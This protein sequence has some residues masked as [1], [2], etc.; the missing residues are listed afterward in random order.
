MGIRVDKLGDVTAARCTSCMECVAACPPKIGSMS[1]GP[2]KWLGWAWPTRSGGLAMGAVVVLVL[3]CLGGAVGATYMAPLPSFVHAEGTPPAETASVIL[4][5][6]GVKCRHGTELFFEQ[7]RRK[8]ELGVRG[9]L[10]VEAWPVPPP[11]AGKVRITYDPREA[12]PSLIQQA[13]MEPVLGPD[14]PQISA[15]E[16]EGYDAL[17]E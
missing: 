14:G 13:I 4:H 5:V 7:L 1:W 6:R 15:Y 11:G 9:Y 16:V 8:D 10:K 3:V 17:A 12:D 2:P